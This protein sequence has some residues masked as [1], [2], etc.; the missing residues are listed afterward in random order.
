MSHTWPGVRH[1]CKC[2]NVYQLNDWNYMLSSLPA[3]QRTQD[4][5]VP[6]TSGVLSLCTF[7]T[8]RMAHTVTCFKTEEKGSFRK[9]EKNPC[10]EY[11]NS[12]ASHWQFDKSQSSRSK[13]HRA[14]IQ[15]KT[16]NKI[17]W[18]ILTSRMDSCSLQTWWHTQAT[19][20]TPPRMGSSTRT[21]HIS[22]NWDTDGSGSL[23]LVCPSLK[24]ALPSVLSI[25]RFMEINELSSTVYKV[26]CVKGSENNKY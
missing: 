4:V 9:G 5:W 2:S 24:P 25:L 17:F 19:R 14:V 7:F 20:R 3:E 12:Q 16:A 8:Q 6:L 21:T 23:S 10:K 22:K 1:H 26:I 18:L 15:V 13:I 11:A